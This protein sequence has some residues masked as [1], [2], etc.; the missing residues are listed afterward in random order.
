MPDNK[1]LSRQI[2]QIIVKTNQQLAEISCPEARK[3]LVSKTINQIKK[4]LENAPVKDL[5]F[6]LW[7]LSNMLS[8]DFSSLL[9][10]IADELKNLVPENQ[11]NRN[12]NTQIIQTLLALTEKEK[13]KLN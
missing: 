6:I 8:N 3:N 7:N 1:L 4:I 13:K 5:P 11:L 12:K 10:L 2:Y 9:S